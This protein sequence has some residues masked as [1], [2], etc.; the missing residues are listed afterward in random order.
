MRFVRYGLPLVIALGGVVLIG[1]GGDVITGTG[2]VLIG[3]AA[4]VLLANAFVRLA[5]ESEDERELEQ[6]ARDF[7]SRHGRWPRQ[8]EDP[9]S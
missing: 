3:V 2:I 4:L 5:I 1:I 8:G 7:F 6:R 9:R